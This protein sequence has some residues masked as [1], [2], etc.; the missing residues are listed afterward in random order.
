MKLG[1]S[2]VRLGYY[3]FDPLAALAYLSAP[4][5]AAAFVI[6]GHKWFIVAAAISIVAGAL[7]ASISQQQLGPQTIAT[8]TPVTNG[9]LGEQVG[10]VTAEGIKP[11]DS[12]GK[13]AE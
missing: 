2:T 13:V 12:A 4:S 3:H 8:G 7:R 9:H 1:R 5:F 10:V 11:T 6:F